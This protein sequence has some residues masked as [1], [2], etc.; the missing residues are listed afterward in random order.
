MKLDLVTSRATGKSKAAAPRSAQEELA[1]SVVAQA[2]A[3]GAMMAF[4][5]LFRQAGY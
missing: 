3:A 2:L 5:R 4:G 1:A